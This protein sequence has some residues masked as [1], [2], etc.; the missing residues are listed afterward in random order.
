M[1]LAVLI[2]YYNEG[3]LLRECLESVLSQP[4]PPD[5][6]LVYDDASTNRPDAHIPQGSRVRIVRATENHGPGYGRN[7]LLRETECEYVHFHDADDL[8]DPEW[9]HEVRA[10]IAREAPDIV[11]TEIRSVRDGSTVSER[12]LGID[13]LRDGGDLVRF[14]L[15]GSL[16][17]PST[18][19]RRDL[20]LS[21]GG[22][23]PREVLAQSEDFDFHIRLAAAAK[24]FVVITRPLIIQR[25]RSGSH[26][27]D[28]ESCWTSAVK[29]IELL[30]GSLPTEYRTDAA[31]AAARVG[32]ELYAI[33]S[34]R[35]AREAFSLARELGPP[36]YRHRP[37]LY[38]WVATM[39][40]PFVA[41][42]VATAYRL[43]IPERVRR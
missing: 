11:L 33:R 12:V 7:V 19:F 41:E 15:R 10:A 22:F 8:F 13:E 36:R 42:Q 6:V 26:S 23:R 5:E 3:A 1:R 31:D 43:L 4:E 17:V 24:S 37:R 20:A 2:T 25:L 27:A 29:A 9:C 39:L 32:S 21:V 14:G 28:M 35:H 16:L 30:S 40:G 38:R 34:R 18:T